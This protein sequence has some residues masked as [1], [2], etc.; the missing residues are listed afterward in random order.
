VSGFLLRLAVNTG[1]VLIASALLG[2]ERFAVGDVAAAILFALVLGL[3]NAVVRPLLLLLTLPLTII[4]L[5]LFILVLNA[6]M[7]VL[8]DMIVPLVHIGSFLD[9]F[10]AALIIAIVNLIA[11]RFIE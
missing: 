9:A 11:D 8:A 6:L 10:L 7:I 4:T 1:A 3:L 5:G 2:P